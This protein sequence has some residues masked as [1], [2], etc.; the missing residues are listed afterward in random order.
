ME[1]DLD[2]IFAFHPQREGD[3]AKYK[4]IRSAAKAF[5]KAIIENTPPSAD[6]SDALRKVREAV[7][8]ANAAVALDGRLQPLLPALSLPDLGRPE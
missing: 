6:Q 7:M 8:V 2:H 5:A 3:P 1:F 4:A